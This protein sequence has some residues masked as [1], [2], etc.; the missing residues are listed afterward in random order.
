MTIAELGD[1]APVWLRE[2][3]T[4]GADVTVSESGWVTWRGG[5]WLGGEWLGGAWLGGTWQGGTWHGGTWR[6]G[7]WRGSENRLL[8]HAAMCGIVFRDGK[9][10]GYR[11]T[12]ANGHGR[13]NAEF[14]QCEGEYYETELP[15]AGSGTC[16]KGIHVASA[17]VAWT[18]FGV[19]LSA[20]LWEVE[21]RAEDLL[22]CDG[23]KAR[24][25]GGVFRKVDRPF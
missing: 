15:P 19:D 8:Y 24:I 9:A 2:A 25:R 11:T 3:N 21:F 18:Y 22:D 7:T 12:L 5:E 6:D 13:H 10:I 23:Q 1:K 4:A 16:V 17:A 20:Q 14:T